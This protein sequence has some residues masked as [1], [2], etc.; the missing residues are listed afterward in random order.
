MVPP[1]SALGLLPPGI[2]QGIWEEVLRQYGGNGRR[3]EILEAVRHA[4]T[5]LARAGCRRLWID[6][7]F[8][9]DK[10]VP[11]DWDGCWDPVGVDPSLLEPVFLDFS[12]AGRHRMKIK[13]LADL[14]PASIREASSG[15]LFVDYF[16][17]DKATGAPKG[18]VLLELTGWNL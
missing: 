2:H 3:R 13:Y 10:F 12:P 4:A 15:L 11:S 1:F 7:S 16:Q 17:I 18:I 6:G 8:V 5:T 9:S 14:F